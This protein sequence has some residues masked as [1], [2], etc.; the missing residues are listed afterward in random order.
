MIHMMNKSVC[1][2]KENMFRHCGKMILGFEARYWDPLQYA[3]RFLPGSKMETRIY[4]IV[5]KFQPFI[6]NF[7]FRYW[8][9]VAASTTQ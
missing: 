3:E 6:M 1:F 8:E 2:F 7:I 4:A 5:I 9:V